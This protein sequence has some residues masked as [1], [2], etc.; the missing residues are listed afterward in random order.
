MAHVISESAPHLFS[1]ATTWRL[2]TRTLRF[3]QRPL[4]MG[5]VNV[6]P[7]SFSDG[8]AFLDRRA[9][10]AHALRLAREGA[11]ILDIG[12]ESTR[13]GSQPVSEDEEIARV[14]PVIAGVMAEWPNAI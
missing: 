3:G 9:A 5:I 13:P 6:T 10:V 2:R 8:G 4:L 12:G 14:L 11:D 7:D 1:R